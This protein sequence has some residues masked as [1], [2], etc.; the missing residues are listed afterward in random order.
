MSQLLY[1]SSSSEPPAELALLSHKITRVDSAAQALADHGNIDIIVIDARSDLS[2]AHRACQLLYN[3]GTGVPRL[4]LVEL[5]ALAVIS[6]D[7]GFTDFIVA[8]AHRRSSMR[9]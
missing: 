5:N 6:R 7:W 8:G 9:A 2:G 3:S 4:L 1:L